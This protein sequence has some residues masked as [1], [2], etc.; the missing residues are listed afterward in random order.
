MTKSIII[1]LSIAYSCL[2]FKQNAYAQPMW[3]INL[4]DSVANGKRAEKFENRRLGSEKMAD[5]K[6]TVARHFFQNN[7]T[8]YNYYFNANNKIN[9]VLERAKA[10]QL[11]DFSK[12]LSYYPFTF[13]N[14]AAQKTELDSVIYKATSG[15]LLHDLRNDWIDNMYLLMGKAYFLKKDFDSAANTFQFINYNL[16]PRK[17]NEDEN[18]IVGTADTENKKQISIA[19]KEKRNVPQKIFTQPPSRNDAL[20]WLARTQ[21]EQE[22]LGDAAGLINILQHDPNLPKRLKDDLA[23][24][25][26]YWYYK[27]GIYDST[28]AY[29]EQALTIA[30]NKLDKSRAE[31]LLAQLFEKTNQFS[32]AS[33]FY[34]K[35][36]LHTTNPVLN[37]YAQLNDAKMRKGNDVKELD[38]GITNLV[39]LSKKDNFEKFNDIIFYAAGELALL[40]PDTN[41][42]IILFTKSYQKN[43]N[44]IVYKN[45]A[46]LQL[47]D[48]AYNRKAYQ[49][50]FN[51]YD[52]LQSGDTTLADRLDQIQARRNALSKI[53]EKISAIQR[54]DS[55]QMIAAMPQAQRD[56]F[57]K[58]LSKKLRKAKGLKEE[59]I[60]STEPLLSFDNNKDAPTDLFASTG[61]NTGEWYFYNSGVKAKG[62]SDFKRKWG[63]RS[64]VDN[65]R[66]K[67]ATTAPKD[68]AAT[69]QDNMTAL[70][71]V[72]PDD[73]D[74]ITTNTDTQNG[75]LTSGGKITRTPGGSS[76]EPLGKTEQQE[77]ITFEGLMANLPLDEIR[78]T[79]S[80][81]SLA[82]NM[83][84]LAKLYQE[85][86]EDYQQAID[87]YDTCL[88]RF[89][90]SLYNGALYFGMY[91]CYTKLGNNAKANYY[92]NLIKTNFSNSQSY[93]ILS[94][95]SSAKPT[96]KNTEGTKRYQAIYNL[97]IEG[98]FA[99]A[100]AEK[101]KADSL[102]GTN[103]WSPQLLY[104]EAVHHI[105][106]KND[107][108]AIAVLTNIGKLYPASKLKPKADKMIDVLKR[109]KEIEDYLTALQI[110]RLKEDSVT[111]EPVRVRM[112]RD[113][114]N[115][116]QPKKQDSSKTIIKPLTT[117]TPVKDS[118]L[119][120]AKTVSGPYVIN[121]AHTHF[122]VMLLNKVDGTY[123]NESKNAMAR[124]IA[125]NYRVQ[126]I[127]VTKDAIDKDNS[128]LIFSIFTNA[129]EAIPVLTKMRKAAPD[130]LS[131][132]PTNK[133]SFII[134][135]EDNLTRL[136][137][138]KDINGYKALLKAQFAGTF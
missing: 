120:V 24:V 69:A 7:F 46:F 97:F 54:E 29:L 127:T 9:A 111:V 22:E 125:D 123:V 49:L 135:D 32:K 56:A 129:A 109:R 33:I 59:D 124:Y 110:T 94:N 47:A 87:T 102:F 20:I 130:E 106:Q 26:A 11:D 45:K 64:N 13:D 27:Q 77:D 138:T 52:S 137:N 128:L 5:K 44:N 80:K 83:F 72:N 131:W 103:Y 90:D 122:I 62:F 35:A 38:K 51:F 118:L 112:I 71:S 126:A 28:A 25:N 57:V 67:S 84:L 37:I 115:L 50:A 108:V 6:F 63:A 58:K 55:L 105:K 99:D 31:F 75:K 96:E 92:R 66:R 76:P 2:F 1:L 136:K 93:K 12:L 117:I 4:I 88:L 86:L 119:N 70:N 121:A 74:A 82:L 40:K 114:N 43:E 81:N 91:Y 95:P 79:A 85:E 15:I 89:P 73:V 116:L 14:T 101:Q 53:V 68:N 48:M 107:S 41:Q 78:L 134:I 60:V 113:D 10:A 133:Y 132:L 18:K 104:I 19:N 21:I 39:K 17:K 30:N 98:K 34:N 100:L 16:F 3:T 8:H 61:K 42:A 23:D 36:S 65:W